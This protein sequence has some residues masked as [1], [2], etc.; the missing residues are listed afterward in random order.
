MYK[1]TRALLTSSCIT[2]SIF[3][4]ASVTVYAAPAGFN[5]A[6]LGPSVT[7]PLQPS[8]TVPA[9]TKISQPVINYASPKAC[10]KKGGLVTLTGKSFGTNNYQ[11][12]AIKSGNFQIDIKTTQWTDT[13]I[14]AQI[15]FI[16]NLIENVNYEIGIKKNN[17]STW[18]ATFRYIRI[19]PPTPQSVTAPAQ[20]EAPDDSWIYGENNGVTDYQYDDNYDYADDYDFYEPTPTPS[21]LEHTNRMGSLIGSGQ[22]P[23]PES[24]Q[25]RTI[26]NK[27]QS[28]EPGE[29]IIVTVDMEDAIAVQQEF[30]SYGIRVKRRQKLTNLGLVISTLGLPSGEQADQVLADIR[31][32]Y[33]N[34]WVSLNTRYQ[35]QSAENHNSVMKMVGWNQASSQCG[36]GMRIGMIDTVIDTSHNALNGQDIL[37]KSMIS[38]G[39]KPADADHG[40]AVAGLLVGNHKNPANSG[41]LPGAKLVAANVF[42]KKGDNVDTTTETLMTALD[43]LISQKVDAV[44]MSLGGPENTLLSLAIENTLSAGIPVISS[45]GNGG[46]NGVMPYPAAQDGVIG[47]TAVD[48]KSNLFDDATPGKHIAF[49]APGVDIWVAQAKQKNSYRSGTSYATPF[50]TA[51]LLLAKQKHPDKNPLKILQANAVDL[52]E[53]GRDVKFGWGLVRLDNACA[54]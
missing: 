35:L 41:L 21:N 42:R 17:L 34:L 8:I 47:V 22:P 54:K 11:S 5:P 29:L 30:S 38:R 31:G 49:S 27:Q 26:D 4:I 51:A 48:I 46:E 40:T 15:P 32:Q 20:T 50:V 28:H 36:E 39:V 14:V 7:K 24:L 44:N 43:W 13:K 9:Q 10:V 2:V 25:F 6:P 52:G 19:C 23:P 53:E 45:A 33:P 18:L 1:Q 37:Q 12:V 3:F 16:D